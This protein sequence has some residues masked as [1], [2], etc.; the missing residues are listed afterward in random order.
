MKGLILGI[1]VIGAFI[2]YQIFGNLLASIMVALTIFGIG[3]SIYAYKVEKSSM[4][5]LAGAVFA[6]VGL[7]GTLTAVISKDKPEETVITETNQNIDKVTETV[8]NESLEKSNKSKLQSTES[9]MNASQ[10]LSVQRELTEKATETFSKYLDTRSQMEFLKSALPTLAECELIFRYKADAK[11]VYRYCEET[12]SKYFDDTEI[13][14]EYYKYCRVSIWMIDEESRELTTY[15]YLTGG[16]NDILSKFTT[17]IP[18]YSVEYLKNYGDDAGMRYNSF[19]YLN[20]RFIFLP[21]VW[22]AFR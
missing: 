8:V 17:G 7:V 2:A 15:E 10:F 6:I 1:A 20:N 19:V 11:I 5:N 22:R 13:E 16:E 4:G 3:L 9:G 21:K 14:I 18:F 12:K